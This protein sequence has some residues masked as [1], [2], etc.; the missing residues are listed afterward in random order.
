MKIQLIKNYKTGTS[1]IAKGTVMTVK[2]RPRN[3]W[4]FFKSNKYQVTLGPHFGLVIPEEYC[5]E[6]PNK[7][8]YTEEE[9]FEMKNLYENKLN[10]LRLNSSVELPREVYEAFEAVKKSWSK[11]LTADDFISLMLNINLYGTTGNALV[12]KKFAAANPIEYVRALANGYKTQ[13]ST[14]TDEVSDIIQDWLSR[15]YIEDEAT[16]VRLFAEKLTNFYKQKLS[17]T[18]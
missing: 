7:K 5:L 3:V 17:K 9:W 2:K 12:L 10:N 15:E 4:P 13:H 16:D 6:L 11:H 14:I 8:T 18:S 1:H